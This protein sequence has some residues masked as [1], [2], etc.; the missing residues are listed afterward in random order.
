MKYLR[1]I[2][3]FMM[4]M[5]FSFAYEKWLIARKMDVKGKN[6]KGRK[7]WQDRVQIG[8]YRSGKQGMGTWGAVT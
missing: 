3:W 8:V 5:M 1:G 4:T 6:G 2:K 7:R